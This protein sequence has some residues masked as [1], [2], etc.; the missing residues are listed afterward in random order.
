MASSASQLARMRSSQSALLLLQF[1]VEQQRA[2]AHDRIHRRPHVVAERRQHAVA[3]A[4][5]GGGL[6]LCRLA[7]GRRGFQLRRQPHLAGHVAADTDELAIR[8]RLDAQPM[9]AF[10]AIV[11]G[12]RHLDAVPP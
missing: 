4:G 9:H 5:D 2:D 7:G 1:A 11:G 12:D 6:F 3:V 8:Q 10:L